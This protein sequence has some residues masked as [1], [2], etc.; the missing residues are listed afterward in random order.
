MKSALVIRQ[1]PYEGIAGFR[2]PVEEAGYVIDRVD[3]TDPEFANVDFDEPDLVVM[4]GG[5]MGVYETERYPWLG[6][7]I[8]RLARRIMLDRPTLGVCL[9]SQI[10]AAAMG[11]RVY[12]GPVKEVGFSPVTI[13]DAGL[14]SP[15]RHI[16]DVPV[17]HWH[18]DT[19]DLP[20]RAELLASSDKYPNQAFRRGDNIL[21]LQ[22][23]SEMGE[24]PRFDAWLEDE[25]YIAAAGLTVGE[26]RAQHDAHGSVAVAA[27]RRMITDWLDR[28]D[29]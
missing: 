27:G 21:A 1:V 25:P 18:G 2:A 29:N 12:A 10:I 6:C 3:V 14:A 11:A 22:C 26:L 15:L 5:P 4:M 7:E 8:A 23:H 13:H 9:G 24:D 20:E 28:L 17:L 19:F 16:E